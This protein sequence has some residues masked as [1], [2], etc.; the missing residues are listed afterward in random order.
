MLFNL[1]M[2]FVPYFLLYAVCKACKPF[3]ELLSLSLFDGFCISINCD[4]KP[5]MMKTS[6]DIL[7]KFNMMN[8]D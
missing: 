1:S 3:I 6:L 7:Q 4:N 8:Y 2:H 5:I